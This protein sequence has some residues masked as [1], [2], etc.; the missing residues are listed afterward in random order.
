MNSVDGLLWAIAGLAIGMALGWWC[1]RKPSIYHVTYR[2]KG[3][4]WAI[5]PP[6]LELPPTVPTPEAGLL[7]MYSLAFKDENI[8][9]AD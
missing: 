2:W 9:E 5:E 3:D 6:D 4:D 1:W 7:K 8:E